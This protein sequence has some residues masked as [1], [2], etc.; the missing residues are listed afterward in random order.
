MMDG[1]CPA[2][3]MGA[4]WALGWQLVQVDDYEGEGALMDDL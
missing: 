1:V 3:S 2:Q 4:H